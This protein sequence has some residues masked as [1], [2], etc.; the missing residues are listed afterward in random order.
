VSRTCD[1]TALRLRRHRNGV[2]VGRD[3]TA[4][5]RPTV[6]FGL[7]AVCTSSGSVTISPPAQAG[8]GSSQRIVDLTVPSSSKG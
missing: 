4:R 6:G 7:F 1:W 8:G 2:E 5:G 3:G